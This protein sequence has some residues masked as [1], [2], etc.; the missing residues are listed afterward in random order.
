MLTLGTIWMLPQGNIMFCPC[1]NI[2]MVPHVNTLLCNKMGRLVGT[3]LCNPYTVCTCIHQVYEFMYNNSLSLTQ[4]T[5]KYMNSCTWVA[6]FKPKTPPSIWI[7]VHELF[8]FEPKM[9]WKHPNALITK[10]YDFLLIKLM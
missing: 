8:E 4:Y 6:M 10:S 1:G 2:C 3:Y 7:H 9:S 5:I